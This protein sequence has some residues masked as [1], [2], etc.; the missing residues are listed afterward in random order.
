MLGLM[1]D[2]PLLISAILEHAARHHPASKIVSARADGS[3]ARHTWPQVAAR[4]AQLAHA[5]VARGAGRG[6]RI[7]TLAWNDH[8]HLE[9][10]YGVSCMGAVMHTVNPR[11]FPDQIAYILAD[12]A[13]RQRVRQLRRPRRDLRPGVLID[14]M[15]M[16]LGGRVSEQIVFGSITTGASDDVQRVA[17]IAFSMVHEY[18]MGTDPTRAVDPQVLSDQMRRQHDEEQRELT[19]AAQRRAE[20]LIRGHRPQLDALAAQLLEHEVLERR[21]IERIMG[22]PR[23]LRIA[24]TAAL[25]D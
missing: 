13:C 7:A 17:K 2:R 5:L 14:Y 19:Y 21:D 8:R 6:E 11:L 10:Y 20:E 1:Q 12:A 9:I 15:A 24:A 22:E 16:L 23:R 4:A 3:L 25:E 18:A